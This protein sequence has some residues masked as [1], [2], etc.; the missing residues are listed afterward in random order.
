[1]YACPPY[2]YG[3]NCAE[4]PSHPNW[5]RSLIKM[6]ANVL[7]TTMPAVS[8]WTM[9]RKY[10][11]SG[12]G[13]HVGPKYLPLHNLYQMR[14]GGISYPTFQYRIA[15]GF[16]I[17]SKIKWK[18][19]NFAIAVAI[20]ALILYF[21]TLTLQ[22]RA[23]LLAAPQN[24]AWSSHRQVEQSPSWNRQGQDRDHW[25]HQRERGNHEWNHEPIR[26]QNQGQQRPQQSQQGPQQRPHKRRRR[27]LTKREK[28][29]VLNSY[30]YRCAH[31]QVK[32]SRFNCDFDHSI[33]HSYG[34]IYGDRVDDIKNF[35]PLCLECHRRKTTC[36]TKYRSM[37]NRRR[38]KIRR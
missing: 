31:C 14:R 7:T 26:H 11:I 37:L 19:W 25:D 24:T 17:H 34:D 30:H 29:Q 20:C 3:G 10:W 8:L 28:K 16:A 22:S 21:S 12:I 2:L 27:R 32:L 33:P 1:M 15:P 5:M 18:M 23:I 9:I 36:E 35:Q 4:R 6:N 13:G 38:Q